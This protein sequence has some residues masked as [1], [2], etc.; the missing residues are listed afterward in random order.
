MT[1]EEMHEVLCELADEIPPELFEE[2]NGGISLQPGLMRSPAAKADDL[3]VLGQYHQGGFMGRYITIHYGSFMRVYGHLDRQAAKDRLRKIL[4]HEF[5]H[6]IE[7]LA[8][9]HDLEVEDAVFI[10]NYLNN[11]HKRKGK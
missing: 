1:M 2:L 6:H 10:Q 11:Y 3:F 8:G 7:S 5:R 4:R 9:N